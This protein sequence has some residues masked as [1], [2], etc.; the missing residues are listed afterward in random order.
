MTAYRLRFGQWWGRFRLRWR[1]RARKLEPFHAL[2]A[3]VTSSLVIVGYIVATSHV[4]ETAK[5]PIVL[6]LGVVE[7]VFVFSRLILHQLHKM[8]ARTLGVLPDDLPPTL[9]DHLN[10]ERFSFLNRARE[11]SDNKVCDL[12]KHE[13][14]SSLIHLTDTVTAQKAGTI[15]GVIYAVS[16]THL[17]DFTREELAQAYLAANQRAVVNFVV[18]QRV[19]L[20]DATQAHSAKVEKLMKM[21]EDALSSQTHDASGVKWLK[22]ADAGD[23]KGLDFALFAREVLVR[24]VHRPGGVKGVKAELTFNESHVEHTLEAFDRLWQ[25]DEARSVAEFEVHR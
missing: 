19:F 18:V 16:S 5:I 21:H 4:E 7:L 10:G 3:V 23:D 2:D 22:K 14:Y 17:E 24:Q 15:G 1:R 11:L 8:S 6:L 20:L 13:M 12:E 25:H 9:F